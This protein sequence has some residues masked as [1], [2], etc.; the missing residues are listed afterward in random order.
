MMPKQDGWHVLQT[1]LNQPDTSRIPVI[2]CSVLKQKELALSLG[3]TAFVEK[4]I[5]EQ[6]LLSALDALEEM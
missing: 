3:A 1:L 4:P 5:T 2:V 6:A